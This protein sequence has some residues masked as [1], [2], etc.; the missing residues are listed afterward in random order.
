[1]K[2]SNILV[3]KLCALFAAFALSPVLASPILGTAQ[4]FSVLGATTVTNT[5]PTT[6]NGDVGVW[7]GTAITGSASISLTGAFHQADA[8]AAQ[9][10]ADAL[11]AEKLLS[12]M[13]AST[14]LTGQDLGGL[15]LTPGVYFFA[16]SAQLTGTLTLDAMN[17]ANALFVFQIG[18]TLTTASASMINVINGNGGSGVFFD[19][20]SSAT[21]GSGSVFAGNIPIHPS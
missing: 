13:S 11:T 15:V 17:D 5:G 3:P 21:L 14:V 4:V 9:A 1:M 8:M 12:N 18:S 6:I 2:V 20:G 7:P 16:S 19:V 10:Q